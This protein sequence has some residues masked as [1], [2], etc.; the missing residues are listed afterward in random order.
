MPCS[1]LIYKFKKILIKM[2]HLSHAM[3]WTLVYHIYVITKKQKKAKYMN[4][5][6][7]LAHW[8]GSGRNNKT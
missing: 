3:H 2:C 5:K 8:P 7:W 1:I 4:L 6:H